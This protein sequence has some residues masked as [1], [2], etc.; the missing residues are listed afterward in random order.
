MKLGAQVNWMKVQGQVTDIGLFAISENRIGIRSG[1][2]RL[3]HH[4]LYFM[5]FN[6]ISEDDE[7]AEAV[8]G[9]NHPSW[10]FDRVILLRGIRTYSDEFRWSGYCPQTRKFSTTLYLDNTTNLFVSLAG[11]SKKDNRCAERFAENIMI[12]GAIESLTSERTASLSEALKKQNLK[13]SAHL[14]AYLNVM[15][16]QKLEDDLLFAMNGLPFAKWIDH[17]TIDVLGTVDIRG[18]LENWPADL[19]ELYTTIFT[20]AAPSNKNDRNNQNKIKNKVSG[21]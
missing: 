18:S 19:I 15:D 11:I 6:T 14:A 2:K 16:S 21:S 7:T 4:G 5:C 20:K 3:K 17:E 10:L 12:L 13:I 8:L 9:L 1:R